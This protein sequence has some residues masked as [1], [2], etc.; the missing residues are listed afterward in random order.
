MDKQVE[1]YYKKYKSGITFLLVISG[2]WPDY[3]KHPRCVRVVLSVISS[4]IEFVMF[5]GACGFC[6]RYLTNINVLVKGLGLVISFS[7]AFP[8]AAVIAMHWKELAKLNRGLS[9]QFERDLELPDNRQHLLAHFPLFLNFFNLLYYYSGAVVTLSVVRPLLA[10]RHGVYVRAYP[11]ILP[12]S[13]EPGGLIHWCI[14]AFE[15]LAGFYCWANTV[16]VDSVFGFYSLQMVGELRLLSSRFRNLKSTSDYKKQLKECIDKHVLLLESKR[17]MQKVFGFLSVFFAITCAIVMCALI[18]QSTEKNS[19]SVYKVIYLIVYCMIKVLQA[20]TYA[21]FGNIITVESEACLNSIYECAWPGSGDL[22]IMNDALIIQSQN[23]MYFQVMGIMIVRLD[24]FSK[25]MHASVSYF[26]LL[27]T[28]SEN[29]ERSQTLGEATMMEKQVANYYKYKGDIV[30]LLAISGL[31]P[32]YKR[33]PRAVKNFL[34][35]ASI[36]INFCTTF[37]IVNFCLRNV[38]NINVLTKGMGLMISYSS[39]LLKDLLLALNR[40]NLTKLNR[41]LSDRFE[42]DLKTPENRPHLLAHHGS[43]HRYFRL[44]YYYTGTIVCIMVL[45]PLIALRH[46]K[47]VR[48][49]PQLVPF[50]YENGGF[51]HWGTYA[52]EL[53]E[54]YFGWSNTV[55]PDS[56]FGLYVLHLVGELRLLSFQFRNLKP[57]DDYR[58]QMKECIDRHEMLIESKRVMQRVFGFPSVWL[59]VTSAV[60]I[61]AI[62]FQSSQIE[63]MT[64]F[65]AVYLLVYTMIKFIQVY[66]YSWFGHII[67]LE[68]ETCIQSIYDAKWAGEGDLRLMKDSIIVLSQ[69]PMYFDA[70]S[71]MIVRLDMFS[72]I[73][74]TSVSYFF[75]LKTLDAKMETT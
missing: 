3:D 55:G 62:I 17:T 54:G 37:G 65:K 8:K 49:Y 41:S 59:A 70:M 63:H 14:Y 31:W 21:W 4:A 18:F 25:I 19:L 64:A 69:N 40:N 44:H 33:Y 22:R 20:Y 23:P 61:C 28:L 27:Q 51:V 56:V 2:L 7:S 5:L 38:T 11:L 35:C 24:M 67:N 47:Y 42:K 50:N 57:G 75:L 16:S 46:G 34:I 15:M 1:R 32:D 45:A 68:S 10:L 36:T 48:A 12:F 60:V 13:Y 30:H 26:F 72:K 73:M 71:I 29:I 52:F 66:T 39:A 58:R 74:N 9:S 6:Y 43:F 53:I